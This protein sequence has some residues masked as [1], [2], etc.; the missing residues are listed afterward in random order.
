MVSGVFKL[1]MPPL[2]TDP[3]ITRG[4]SL[5]KGGILK[6]GRK[7]VENFSPPAEEKPDF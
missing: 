6:K 4:G 1:R 7:N 5:I 2:V 3:G